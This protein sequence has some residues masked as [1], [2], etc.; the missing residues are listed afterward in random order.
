[1]GT[2]KRRLLY[3]T[4]QT[5]LVAGGLL[6]F[7]E[8]LLSAA[9]ARPEVRII[10]YPLLLLAGAV[11]AYSLGS[12]YVRSQPPAKGVFQGIGK[13]DASKAWVRRNC[14]EPLFLALKNAGA[15]TVFLVGSSGVGKSVLVAAETVPRLRK[16]GWSVVSI[17]SYDKIDAS[18]LEELD[19]VIANF[20]RDRFLRHGEIVTVDPPRIIFVCD[21]FEH[22]LALRD[23]T[24][25]SGIQ[26]LDWFCKFL[27]TT[28]NSSFV[29]HLLIVRKEFYYDLRLLG[30]ICP[31]PTD[32]FHL[33]GLRLDDVTTKRMLETK[34]G[35]SAGNDAIATVVL[36]SLVKG[37]E[38]LP[39][40]AQV[41]GLMLENKAK[42]QPAMNEA[43]YRRDLGGKEGLIRSYFEAYLNAAPNRHVAEKVLFALSIER[44][45]KRQLTNLQIADI[46]HDSD[47]S[48]Q[49]CLDFLETEGLVCEASESSY[50]LSHDYL[51]ERFHDLSGS[52][53]EAVERDNVL[54]FWQEA[55]KTESRLRI[56]RYMR[57][58]KFGGFN[59][60]LLG[61]LT[62]VVLFR[63]I[64]PFFG[65]KWDWL[66]QQAL[67]V[68]VGGEVDLLYAPIFTA[69]LCWSVYVAMLYR[70]FFGNL[71]EP[72]A[73]RALSVFTVVNCAACVLVATLFPQVWVLSIAVGG[74]G[75][76]LKFL[77][78][79]QTPGLARQ[80]R[81]FFRQKGIVTIINCLILA[82]FG[83]ALWYFV[84][85]SVFSR[86]WLTAT[87]VAFGVLLTWFMV[88]ITPKHITSAATSQMRGLID[89]RRG[90][91]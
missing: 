57:A 27:S 35:R 56:T 81:V 59:D 13:I 36:E 4:V 12:P 78:L 31:A 18:L 50:E 2:S 28:Q 45:M 8:P 71:H 44:S 16:E 43:Y 84:E 65:L 66:H 42:L 25:A 3:D 51:A 87:F 41:V 79:C 37:G 11:V 32:A 33:A 9:A 63:L 64:S 75:V 20:D 24:T 47:L 86:A 88:A 85:R 60:Y 74:L 26:P 19:K 83:V 77:A 76:G 62:I 48:V 46:I 15:R 53:I 39:V 91:V 90:G 68:P 61:F 40:E 38:V 7:V 30:G 21:Q 1:M 82:V 72:L 6:T 80:S 10:A 29:R 34:I 67:L 22:L 52:E 55:R 70:R 17:S 73:A 54:F 49:R 5:V 89:R 58:G 69:H 14:S 23:V